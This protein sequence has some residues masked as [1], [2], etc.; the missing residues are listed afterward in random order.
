MPDRLGT[1]TSSNL[2]LLA[3]PL[4]SSDLLLLPIGLSLSHPLTVDSELSVAGSVDEKTGLVDHLLRLPKSVG[5]VLVQLGVLD[6][7]V[8]VLEELLGGEVT[9]VV[10]LG[11]HLLEVDVVRSS[12]SFEDGDG[13]FLLESFSVDDVSVDSVVVGGTSGVEIVEIDDSLLLRSR[14]SSLELFDCLDIVD[15][16]VVVVEVLLREGREESEMRRIESA[17]R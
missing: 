16:L 5:V 17:L 13:L 4:R 11:V 2:L 3:L 7:L 10:E 14:G 8:E 1:S 9:I 15:G 12:R 6:D